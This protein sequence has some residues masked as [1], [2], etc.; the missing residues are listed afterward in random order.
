[1]IIAVY[2]S[3]FFYSCTAGSGGYSN[4]TSDTSVVSPD[5]T[6]PINEYRENTLTAGSETAGSTFYEISDVSDYNTIH[7][8]RQFLLT[9]ELNSFLPFNISCY[10]SNDTIS[11]LIPAGIDLSAVKVQFKHSG[12]YLKINGKEIISGESLLDLSEP[13]ELTAASKSGTEFKIMLNIETLNTGIPSVALTTEGCRKINSK[14]NYLSC[15][16][17]IGGGNPDECPYA[18]DK[19]VFVSGKVK[20]RGNTSWGFPKKGYTIK[21]DDKE[22]LLDLPASNDWT[23]ISNYQDKTLIRNDFASKLADVV[24]LEANMQTRSVDLWL[25]GEYWGNYTLTEKIEIEK[26]RIDIPDFDKSLPPDKVGYLFEW[27]GHI[28]EIPEKQK[29]NWEYVEGVIYDPAQDAYFINTT[30]WLVIK[31]PSSDDLTPEHLR[32]VYEY[33]TEL[34]TAMDN[35]DYET[36]SRRMDLESFVKW[37]FVEDIMKNMDACFWSSCYMY[38]DGSGILHM[39]PVWDFDMSLGNCN[40]GGCDTP[41]SD[42]LSGSWYYRHLLRMP[43]YRALTKKIWNEK[44]DEILGMK[45]YVRDTVKMLE[46]SIIHNFS[47]WDILGHKV[48]ANPENVI[49]AKTYVEQIDI[50]ID[51]FE[52]RVDFVDNFIKNLE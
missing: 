18:T 45:N 19:I 37:Y 35:G 20:G 23:L 16:F 25:N 46:K 15:T 33:I 44:Y 31:K 42:Y 3:L 22:G 26:N 11:A 7:G 48:G 43:E 14:T 38:I 6:E 8:L 41:E 2:S 4:E 36:V 13:A 32:Y 47:V 29:N 21:L 28:Q 30:G 27:D 12:K 34:E 5:S 24:G 10:I 51:F 39:G 9:T 40:Y 50:M 52:Q 17:Y 49:R 1:M